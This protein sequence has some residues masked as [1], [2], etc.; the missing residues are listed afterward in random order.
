VHIA[1]E[2]L[3]PLPQLLDMSWSQVRAISSTIVE[4]KSISSHS[5]TSPD[6]KDKVFD[7]KQSETKMRELFEKA[8]ANGGKV[9]LA[10][11]V[12]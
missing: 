9:S 11:L 7:E 6:S 5:R 1:Q 4:L 3:I 8:K 12:R 2:C 10:D